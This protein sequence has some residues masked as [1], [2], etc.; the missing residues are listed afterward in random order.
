MILMQC[1]DSDYDHNSKG[2]GLAPWP[3]RLTSPPPRLSDFGYSSDMFEKDTELWRKRV[4]NYWDLL[5]PKISTHTI[6]NVMD[7]K[8]NLGSF[9]A[10]LSSK[11]LLVMNVVPE[12][13]PN[14]L[15]LIYDRGLIGSNHN[16]LIQFFDSDDWCSPV[17]FP[18]F[19]MGSLECLVRYINH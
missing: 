19:N 16:C 10:V 11:D 13:G 17:R 1:M 4:E 14:T 15:K 2:S 6:R 12:D 9:R 8:E 3:A 5:S 7:I 18:T